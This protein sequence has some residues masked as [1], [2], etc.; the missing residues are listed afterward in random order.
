MLQ[1]EQAQRRERRASLEEAALNDELNAEY[2]K[3]MLFVFDNDELRQRQREK[4][5]A[6]HTDRYANRDIKR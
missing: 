3:Q 4:G 2:S 5:T 1:R 6:N